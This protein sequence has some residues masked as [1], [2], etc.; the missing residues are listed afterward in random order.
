VGE[1]RSNKRGLPDR[2]LN[3]VWNSAK[4][5]LLKLIRAG[6]P[7]GVRLPYRYQTPTD[8]AATPVMTNAT[9]RFLFMPFSTG[10]QACDHLWEEKHQNHD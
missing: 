5:A 6:W 10:N 8:K 7:E 4:F 1:A 2:A 3:A 9:F